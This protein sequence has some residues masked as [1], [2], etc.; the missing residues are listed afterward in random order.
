MK[1]EYQTILKL[2]KTR[3]KCS[4]KHYL[5]RGHIVMNSKGAVFLTWDRWPRIPFD[6]DFI[7]SADSSFSLVMGKNGI[8]YLIDHLLEVKP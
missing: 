7:H 3:L 2:V 6:V 5:E 4:K 1:S 8:D